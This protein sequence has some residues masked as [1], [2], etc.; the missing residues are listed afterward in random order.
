MD[1]NTFQGKHVVDGK[2]AM[3]EPYVIFTEK[4]SVIATHVVAIEEEGR[5]DLIA[6]S[7]YDTE[8]MLDL[9]LK[10]NGISNP[11]GIAAGDVLEIPS[12]VSVFKKFTKPGRPNGN[13][14]KEQFISERRMTKKDIKR[15]DFIQAKSAQYKNGS[16]APLPPN[17]LKEGQT[18]TKVVGITREANGPLEVDRK[19]E[20]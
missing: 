13:T 4:T 7:Y 6:L 10:W 15:L 19:S 12:A 1:F 9:I 16:S 8:Y 3:T 2:V 11:F 5:P 18:N 20:V 14:K 17:V